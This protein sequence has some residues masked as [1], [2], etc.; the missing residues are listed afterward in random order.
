MSKNARSRRRWEAMEEGRS[1]FV[2]RWSS[3]SSSASWTGGLS[4]VSLMSRSILA[5][6][7]SASALVG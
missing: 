4:G 3:Y 2:F 5:L 1:C 7:F 6:A